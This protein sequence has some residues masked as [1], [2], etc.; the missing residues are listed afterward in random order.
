[1]DIN[2]K[3]LS[4]ASIITAGLASLCC[5]GPVV[6]A[7]LGLGAFGAGALFDSLRPYMLAATAAL[8]GAAFYLTYR[9]KSGE[10]C[11]DGTCAVPSGQ[12]RQRVLLWIVTAVI[13]PIAAFPYYAGIF[14]GGTSMGATTLAAS[15]STA[16]LTKVV[17]DVEGMTCEGCAAGI[18]ATLS[19]KPG[20][21]E[22]VV[23]YESKTARFAFDPARISVD[24]IKASIAELGYQATPRKEAKKG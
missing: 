23:D 13:V 4:A 7:A 2:G 10:Q 12:K 18:Q 22:A 9:K 20:I 24:E 6:A 21:A 16:G 19:R 1:M 5:I 14:S 17:F 15:P 3:P 11:A 8:L